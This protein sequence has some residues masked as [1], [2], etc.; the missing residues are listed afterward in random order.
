MSKPDVVKTE[1][2]APDP[3]TQSPTL[4]H[5]GE[6]AA[7]LSASLAAFV[8]TVPDFVI[9]N[10]PSKR[11]MKTKRGVPKPFVGTA[12]G[13][14]SASDDLKSVPQLD[15]VR[16]LDIKQYIDAFKPLHD[17]L[18]TVE[19]GLG[20]SLGVKQ[21]LL[22]ADAQKI[23][24]VAKGLARDMDGGELVVHVQNMRRDL[25][26]R[27]KAVKQQTPSSPVPSNPAPVTSKE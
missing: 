14:V 13:A 12:F 21:A 5:Y 1:A 26:R 25:V 27:K 18:I 3:G 6:V 16:A 10:P 20:Y 23:Y 15:T 9:A 19:R 11:F 17:Q 7:Q 8:A 22:A 24:A 2:Q 4:T